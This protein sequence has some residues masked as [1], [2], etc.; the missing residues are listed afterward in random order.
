MNFNQKIKMYKQSDFIKRYKAFTDKFLVRGFVKRLYPDILI[1]L[2]G[3]W[4]TADDIDFDSLPNK[5]V[6]KATHGYAMNIVV[7]DKS[8]I[9]LIDTRKKL[10]RWIDTDFGKKSKQYQYP[11]HGTIIC[12]EFLEFQPLIDYKFYCFYGVVDCC[13]VIY[14]DVKIKSKK[15]V[16]M[17]FSRI[18]GG[19]DKVDN[20]PS[21]LNIPYNFEDMKKIASRLSTNFPHVR[22]DLYNPVKDKI[23]FGELTFTSANGTGNYNNEIS[24]RLSNSFDLTEVIEYGGK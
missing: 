19:M 24:R 14:R 9:N 22:V 20:P 11:E 4:E 17:N 23:F 1:P 18:D 10:N 12:E 21:F 5:F 3:R 6:L 13:R 16:D 7:K 8:K 2:L 15:M